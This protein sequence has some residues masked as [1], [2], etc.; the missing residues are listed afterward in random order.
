[1]PLDNPVIIPVIDRIRTDY[2]EIADGLLL[3]V[4]E[5]RYDLILDL[6]GDTEKN[7]E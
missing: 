5:F 1:M 4:N 2:S 6:L 3:L 7:D